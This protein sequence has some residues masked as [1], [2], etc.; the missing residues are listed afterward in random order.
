MAKKYAIAIFRVSG[1]AF[2]VAVSELRH[3]KRYASLHKGAQCHAV[4]GVS[5]ITVSWR[6]ERIHLLA[7]HGVAPY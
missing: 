3:D 5:P 7:E 4:Q 6:D 1:A 2:L